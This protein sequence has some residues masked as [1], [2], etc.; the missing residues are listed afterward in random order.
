MQWVPSLKA[1]GHGMSMKTDGNLAVGAGHWMQVC[2]RGSMTHWNAI[3]CNENHCVSFFCDR[4]TKQEAQQW[5]ERMA[6]ERGY[7]LAGVV[8]E[9]PVEDVF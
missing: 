8:V 5:G 4:P 3:I 7:E 6:A 1:H 9:D 2:P